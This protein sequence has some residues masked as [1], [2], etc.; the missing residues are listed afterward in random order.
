VQFFV[1]FEKFTR[2][3]LFQIAL[4]II[5]LPIQIVGVLLVVVVV[6][7]IVVVAVVDCSGNGGNSDCGGSG[8]G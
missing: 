5:W 1:E 4:E 7:V 8:A 6:V 2:A 3:Y